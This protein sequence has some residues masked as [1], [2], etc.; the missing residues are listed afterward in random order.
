MFIKSI[1]L[2][3]LIELI[4]DRKGKVSF[5]FSYPRSFNPTKQSK[6]ESIWRNALKGIIYDANG[7]DADN[8]S[9]ISGASR[10]SLTFNTENGTFE[11][12]E[13]TFSITEGIAAGE[14]FSSSS[15][16]GDPLK[17]ADKI[18]CDICVDVGG[19]TTDYSIWFNDR[20]HFD[21][22]VLLAGK[23]ISSIF[24]YN[25]R[26]KNLLFSKDAVA[27]LEE[28]ANNETLFISRLNFILKKEESSISSNL[29]KQ[30]NNKDINWMRWMLAL[31]FASLAYY[32]SNLVLGLNVHLK[33]KIS[34][35]IKSGGVKLFWGEMLRNSLAG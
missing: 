25:P 34:E 18:N 30:I 1:L 11:I 23:T 19:G 2:L 22:S 12:D 17:R 28:V 27:A 4:R 29:V 8:I 31:E 9:C 20:I 24:K 15:I 16:I 35:S 14:Y 33:G 5:R 26:I 3:I 10:S 21:T 32:S 6:Y 13:N 7:S